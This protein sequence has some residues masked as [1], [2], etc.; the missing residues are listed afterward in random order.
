MNIDVF[1]TP[2]CYLLSLLISL[3]MLYSLGFTNICTIEDIQH[4]YPLLDMVD[5]DHRRAVAKGRHHDDPDF[6]AIEGTFTVTQT[7]E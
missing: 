4:A 7:Y 5:H 6:P 3:T 2:R 1:I